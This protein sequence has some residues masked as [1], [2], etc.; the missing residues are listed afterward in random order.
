MS[1]ISTF[2]SIYQQNVHILDDDSSVSCK[3]LSSSEKNIRNK[4]FKSKTMYKKNFNLDY[5][6]YVFTVTLES[7]EP[8]RCDKCHKFTDMFA[9]AVSRK[10]ARIIKQLNSS[11]AR[12]DC[13]SNCSV[14]PRYL[15][16]PKISSTI[17][18]HILLTS[19]INF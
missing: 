2:S 14:D 17:F 8:C 5:S 4:N 10:F 9:N 13:L 16:W 1:F 18:E 11:R 12:A 6:K 3:P 19:P 7:T 15:R